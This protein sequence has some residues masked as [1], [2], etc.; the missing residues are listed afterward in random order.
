VS[1]GNN[2][3][4]S[5]VPDAFRDELQTTTAVQKVLGFI[6]KPSKAWLDALAHYRAAA[7]AYQTSFSL[8]MANDV[9]L[10]GQYVAELSARAARFAPGMATQDLQASLESA[11]KNLA[12]LE[13]LLNSNPDEVARIERAALRAANARRLQD[14][15]DRMNHLRLAGKPIDDALLDQRVELEGLVARDTTEFSRQVVRQTAAG[16]EIA[17]ARRVAIESLVDALSERIVGCAEEAVEIMKP[18]LAVHRSYPRS[19]PSAAVACWHRAIEIANAARA[20]DPSVIFDLPATF[21]R[22][23]PRC[24]QALGQIVMRIGSRP[25]IEPEQVETR[26]E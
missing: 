15:S 9:A 24:W 21:K 6:S 8:H 7:W 23:S 4:P 26:T 25:K 22:V 11:R 3:A 1:K 18:R 2:A 20:L 19:I 17:A 14:L 5:S 12:G 13:A 16:A 10:Q